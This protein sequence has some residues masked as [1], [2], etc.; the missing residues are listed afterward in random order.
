M[1]LKSSPTRHAV[2]TSEQPLSVRKRPD[3]VDVQTLHKNESAVVLKDPIAMKYHRLRPDEFFLLERL[4]HG[5]TLAALQQD[6]H[7]EFC[8][9]KVTPAQINELLLRF[10]RLGLTVSDQPDQGD[11]YF[12]KLKLERRRRLMQVCSSVLF[13]RFPG[14][15]PEP[16][17]KRLYPVVRPLFSVIGLFIG[18][19]IVLA[20]LLTIAGHW[21]R[22][23][24]EFPS[25]Q[26]WIQ[27]HAVLLLAAVIGG[28]KV[29]HELGHAMVCKHFGGECHQIG[30]MLLVFT[31]ALYC[32]TTDSWML[33]NRYARAAVGMAG[34]GTEVLLASIAT[35][36]WASTGASLL[37]YV[38]M[39]V[40]LVCSISTLLFNAN[41]LLRYDGYYVLSD[42]CDV[43]NLGEKSRGLLSRLMA[44]VLFGVRYRQHDPT[45]TTERFWLLVYAISATIYRWALTLFILWLLLVL[46]RPY[47]LESL[48]LAIG[49]FAAVGLI[50]TS[51]R[52]PF[53]FLRN[54]GK[55]RM[56]KTSN[57]VRSGIGVVILLAIIWIPLPSGESASGSLFPRSETSIY[58]ST[59]G[60]LDQLIG[61][62]GQSVQRDQ[63]IAKLSNPEVEHQYIESLARVKRQRQLVE[64][65]KSSQAT[66][67]EIA[68]ELPVAE[69]MLSEFER[70]LNTRKSRREALLIRS[71]VS[72]RLIEP[73]RQTADPASNPTL[74]LTSW[75]GD[76][77]ETRNLGC[78]IQPGSELFAV[79]ADD[80]WDAELIL[81]GLQVQ[82]I[83]VGNAVKLVVESDPAQPIEGVVTEIALKQW[84]A[85]EDGHRRDAPDAIAMQESLEV[86]YA[87]RVQLDNIPD[88]LQST[89]LPGLLT[90]A[91]IEASP[92]SI[93]GWLGR[94]VSRL[95][96]IR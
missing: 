44:G 7:N 73:P 25:M 17:L 6:Y 66:H 2:P 90:N 8:P 16:I 84:T 35:L 60:H 49:F 32:D 70:Q 9:Q 72:G 96:R 27:L 88:K 37:H 36:V 68:D 89:L 76:P 29:L 31:P 48:G 71:P 34:I 51:F 86:S 87:V 91:R 57:L 94:L 75:T 3:L 64:A 56:M 69:T 61:A 82:R 45:S 79:V 52:A 62:P 74:T 83:K 85:S 11:R 46:L 54:P 40:M 47:R 18:L 50:V 80:R 12:E 15:D 5:A 14:V 33:P 42:L 22:F 53:M 92:C 63:I 19:M 58:V 23:Q 21:S 65:L 77:T 55:R 39:N 38:A 93:A 13:I 78:F 26:Q 95:L 67:P 24:A 4:D 41:P 10:H 59:A 28:T 20:A 43:P 81:T 1:K 30:P